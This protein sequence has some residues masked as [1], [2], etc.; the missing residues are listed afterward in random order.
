LSAEEYEA[1]VIE[2]LRSALV[3]DNKT[4]YSPGLG[5]EVVVTAVEQQGQYPTTNVLVALRRSDGLR[6]AWTSP[7]WEEDED[8]ATAPALITAAQFGGQIV[9]DLNEDVLSTERIHPPF[10]L[11]ET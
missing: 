5:G 11:V 7:L 2:W 4:V 3:R 8:W 1:Q 9:Q 6:I 10:R